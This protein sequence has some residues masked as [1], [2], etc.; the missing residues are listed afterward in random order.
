M[1][2][3]IA[4]NNL[5][6][7]LTR[8]EHKHIAKKKKT[9]LKFKEFYWLLR[10]ISQLPLENKV[11]VYKTVINLIW[12]Y[13]TELW[14]CASESSIAL[15][16]R[17]KPKIFDQLRMSRMKQSLMTLT[18]R[19]S[20]M[21]CKNETGNTTRKSRNNNPLMQSLL[22][23]NQQKAEMTPTSTP[24]IGLRVLLDGGVFYC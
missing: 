22:G 7:R 11:L 10:K 18:Y 1:P 5:D 24:Q 13:C 16:H 15:L 8:I 4:G 2:T 23:T 12:T 14:I 19:P 17:N 9:H 20:K 6:K 21:K 3:D